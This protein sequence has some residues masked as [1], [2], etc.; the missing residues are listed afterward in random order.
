MEEEYDG[1]TT[2]IDGCHDQIPS[3]EEW[4][5]FKKYNE[6]NEKIERWRR[7]TKKLHQKITQYAFKR[8]KVIRVLRPR[9]T[10]KLGELYCTEEDARR[11]VRLGEEYNDLLVEVEGDYDLGCNP[12]MNV[13]DYAAT[14]NRLCRD[15]NNNT[16]NENDL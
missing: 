15:I 14:I 6:T 4:R 8:I 10:R 1:D 7:Q 2:D 16:R 5:R 12:V 3:P 13:D 9:R 11:L